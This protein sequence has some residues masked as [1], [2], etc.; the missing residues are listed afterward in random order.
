[1]RIVE[2]CFEGRGYGPDHPCMVPQV[3]LCLSMWHASARDPD[4]EWLML[5]AHGPARTRTLLLPLLASTD[6]WAKLAVTKT[7]WARGKWGLGSLH[8]AHQVAAG[9]S[10]DRPVCVWHVCCGLCELPVLLHETKAK[11]L[12]QR[13]RSSSSSFLTPSHTSHTPHRL[14]KPQV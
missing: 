13:L 4:G 8:T 12:S 10:Q 5:H 14:Y 7:R 11:K 6:F 1:M 9:R 3:G 2:S